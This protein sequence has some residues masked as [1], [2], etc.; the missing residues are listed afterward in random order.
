MQSIVTNKDINPGK[1]LEGIFTGERKIGSSMGVVLLTQ[2]DEVENLTKQYDHENKLT[3]LNLRDHLAK[4]LADKPDSLAFIVAQ[5]SHRYLAMYNAL[6]SGSEIELESPVY[7]EIDTSTG[8]K[9]SRAQETALVNVLMED[10]ARLPEDELGNVAF[11]RLF[12]YRTQ[13]MTADKIKAFAAGIQRSLFPE[14]HLLLS[15]NETTPAVS[16]AEDFL[17]T[18]IPKKFPPPSS[19]GV[20]KVVTTAIEQAEATEAQATETHAA[21]EIQ[22]T[23][24]QADEAQ[25]AAEIQAKKD[26]LQAAKTEFAEFFMRKVDDKDINLSKLS[27]KVLGKQATHFYGIKGGTIP[28]YDNMT[29]MLEGRLATVLG[30]NATELD[31]F[32][33]LWKNARE[34]MYEKTNNTTHRLTDAQK[35]QLDELVASIKSGDMQEV[36]EAE[37]IQ[38]TE[39]QVEEAQ[40]EEAQEAETTFAEF[41]GSKVGASKFTQAELSMGLGRSQGFLYLYT[42]KGDFPTYETMMLLVGGLATKLAL[43]DAELEVLIELWKRDAKEALTNKQQSDLDEL[44]DRIKSG[45]AQETEPKAAEEMQAQETEPKAEEAQEAETTFA[46]FIRQKVEESGL[47]KSQLSKDLDIYENGVYKFTK[48]GNSRL[49]SQEIMMTMLSKGLATKL[50]LANDELDTLVALWKNER[51]APQRLKFQTLTEREEAALDELVAS[52]KSGDIQEAQAAEEIQETEPQAAEQPQVEEAQEAEQVSV[53]YTLG[54]LLADMHT[55]LENEALSPTMRTAIE[56]SVLAIADV[57]VEEWTSVINQGEIGWKDIETYAKDNTSFL[58]TF[59][60]AVNKAIADREAIIREKERGE[61]FHAVL[62]KDTGITADELKKHLAGETVLTVE[63][64]GEICVYTSLSCGG[65]AENRLAVERVLDA[66]RQN[67]MQ[68]LVTDYLPNDKKQILEKAYK[69]WETEKQ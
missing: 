16:T 59:R 1:A 64:Y 6:V 27:L 42:S 44:V 13:G 45:T 30:L 60:E 35:E 40:V 32:I 66:L 56:N 19:N 46:E 68:E 49:P 51:N 67:A 5:Y 26:E 52:I 41:L 39:P 31:E 58:H 8:I 36:Q 54:N 9:E 53:I 25:E 2:N 3:P 62:E 12:S 33:E 23:E 47:S 55:L 17:N 34:K 11:A 18:P 4:L 65:I 50:D 10:T 48:V 28:Q 14:D 21:E 69:I 43:S 29:K 37:E 22:E 24:P 63:E 57:A 61:S 38:E 7:Y 20:E 15:V